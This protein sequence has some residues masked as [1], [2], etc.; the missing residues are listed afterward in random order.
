MYSAS[1]PQANGLPWS[2]Q[3]PR[4]DSSAPNNWLSSKGQLTCGDLY[5]NTC[6]G[7]QARA[8][9][10]VVNRL[11]EYGKHLIK[12]SLKN[13]LSVHSRLQAKK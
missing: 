10:P 7:A 12:V 2:T 4:N 1:L 8:E 3:V 5:K 11:I 6:H 13:S 9:D